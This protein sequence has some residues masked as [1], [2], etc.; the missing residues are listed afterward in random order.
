MATFHF[1]DS[2]KAPFVVNEFG[3]NGPATPS[4]TLPLHPLAVGANTS[5]VLVGKGV[6]NYGEIVQSSVLYL[7]ENFANSTPPADAVEGQLWYQNNTKDLHLYTGTA[8]YSAVFNGQSTSPL[9][10]NNQRIINL[11]APTGPTDAT[12]KSYTDLTF[13]KLT[14]STMT[15]G[16][17]LSGDPTNA[18]HAT[19]K[20]YTDTAITTA[21]S[22]GSI[23]DHTYTDTQVATKVSKAGDTITGTLNLNHSDLIVN[24]G[25]IKLITGSI[26]LTGTSIIDFDHSRLSSV[27]D[28]VDTSDAI[29]K[30]YLDSNI[31]G[32][33]ITNAVIDQTT[34][35]VSLHTA[36]GSIP[37]T[38]AP[39]S[40][41]VH[42]HSSTDIFYPIFSQTAIRSFIADAFIASYYPLDDA[43]GRTVTLKFVV[44]TFNATIRKLIQKTE[45]HI[46]LGNGTATINLPFFYPVHLDKLSIYKDGIK[47]YRNGRGKAVLSTS[48]S[49]EIQRFSSVTPT[50][51]YYNLVVDGTSYVNQPLDLSSITTTTAHYYDII[52][53]F[54][55]SLTDRGH[56][57]I[58]L[59]SAPTGSTS[60]G[61]LSGTTY[62]AT[63][64]LNGNAVPFTINGS[65]AL[66]Y[67][68]LIVQIQNNSVFKMTAEIIGSSLRLYTVARGA[69]ATITAVTDAV[70]PS[71]A[72][73]FSSLTGYASIGPYV[74]GVTRGVGKYEGGTFVFYSPTVGSSSDIQ[75][76]VPTAGSSIL[77]A[78]GATSISTP[79]TSAYAYSETG[80]PLRYSSTITFSTSTNAAATYEFIVEPYGL[81]TAADGIYN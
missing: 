41:F 62:Y 21:V 67:A 46:Q 20:Q 77:T 49:F 2:T 81:T 24:G 15:G 16:L 38:T 63:L 33:K 64:M 45:R 39:V 1:T 79:G 51:Y 61:L 52:R 29:N 31:S 43:E 18:L 17:T 55:V 30:S 56:V 44:D 37:L 80:L 27:G 59:A 68:D 13:V 22:S 48:G 35:I 25:S 19:T 50:T 65:N 76:N 7:L 28:P 9:D 23:S 73:L 40:P 32:V 4:S 3:T 71:P 14:G 60:T 26:L 10:L 70:G 75:I 58:N 72:P 54:N 11:A 53:A 5:L 36:V 66:T 6:I 69:E 12:N 74:S 8:W 57:D 34:G 47:L 78:M 42:T